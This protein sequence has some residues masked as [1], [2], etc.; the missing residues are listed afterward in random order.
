[1]HCILPTASIN[2]WL[3]DRANEWTCDAPTTARCVA[4]TVWLTAELR[5]LH[6]CRSQV[7]H[8]KLLHTFI[9][10]DVLC[11]YFLRLSN[12]CNVCPILMLPPAVV[13]VTGATGQGQGFYSG[14]Y[15]A[16]ASLRQ[17][18]AGPMPCHWKIGLA[19]G[20]ACDIVKSSN[21]V[22]NLGF[23]WVRLPSEFRAYLCL[24]GFSVFLFFFTSLNVRMLECNTEIP[25]LD[26]PVKLVF[27]LHFIT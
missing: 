3:T 21:F 16:V 17:V 10:G 7:Q 8:F 18:L 14:G 4:V 15:C 22:I 6:R 23:R 11:L 13:S 2:S 9:R 26:E 27:K 19:L 24:F 20:P 25:Y 1:M 12:R 5:R